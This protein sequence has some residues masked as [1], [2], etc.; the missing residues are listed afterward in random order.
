MSKKFFFLLNLLLMHSVFVGN[1]YYILNGGW[2]LKVLCSAGFAVMGL[3]NLGYSVCHNVHGRGFQWLMASG[4]VLSLLADATIEADFIVG[5]LLFG[6]AHV[7]YVAAHCRL[8]PIQKKDIHISWLIFT[9]ALVFLLLCPWLELPDHAMRS[10]CLLYGALLSLMLGKALVGFVRRPG[11]LTG[12]LAVGSGLFFFSDA[13]L[14]LEWFIDQWS[15]TGTLCMAT[16]YPGQCLLALAIL[17]QVK[18][19]RDIREL[20]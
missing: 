19:R 17:L 1:Y 13:M 20:Q 15:I 10:V 2:H 16:Y 3:L 7:A 4:L 12:V 5:V 14:V 18:R 11:L 9:G 6:A 8:M